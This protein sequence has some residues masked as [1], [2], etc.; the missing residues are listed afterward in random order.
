MPYYFKGFALGRNENYDD[1]IKTL[2]QGTLIG[3]D[4]N[5]LMAQMY[6]QL[7]DAYNAKKEYNKSDES[8]EEALKI[9][10]ENAT[11]LNN[12]SYYLSLRGDRLEVAK[13]MADKANKLEPDN[14]SFQ[15]T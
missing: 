7:A 2:K 4:N 15:D 5:A 9:D 14:A 6:S 1:A 8:F 10:P 12:Y 3:S 13:D 11:A